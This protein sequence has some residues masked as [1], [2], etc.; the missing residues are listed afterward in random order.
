MPA[1]DSFIERRTDALVIRFEEAISIVQHRWPQG[2]ITLPDPNAMVVWVVP[3]DPLSDTVPPYGDLV[4]KLHTLDAWACIANDWD[5]ANK[6]Q[7]A[8]GVPHPELIEQRNGVHI[9]SFNNR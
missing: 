2:T 6:A 4:N 9:S 1:P 3:A 5:T 8:R 7:R